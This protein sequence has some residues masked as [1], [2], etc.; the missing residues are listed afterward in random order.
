MKKQKYIHDGK[1]IWCGREEPAVTFE[2]KPHILP[3]ALGGDEICVD[4]CDECNHYFG[5]AEKYLPNIDLVVREILEA[6]RLFGTNYYENR[7]T[8]K[9]FTFFHYDLKSGKIKLKNTFRSG[10]ITFQFK[11]GLYELFLQKYHNVTH[12]GNDSC[13]DWVRQY[14]RYG[15]K[16]V[17]REPR[18][19]YA[20]NNI[21]FTP[22]EEDQNSV[23]MSDKLIDN[24]LKYGVFHMFLM[25]QNFFMEVLPSRFQ[26]YGEYYL[27][28]E[29]TKMLVNVKGDESV[30][31]LTNILDIDPFMIRYNS[32]NI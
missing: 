27:Q 5:T 23:L 8:P 15:S 19:Y 29:A 9:K 18:V 32:Q 6:Y 13:W 21:T 28:N 25:G 17:M 7:K 16:Y 2:S 1:C 12:N 14:A 30:Y 4:V 20:F 31:E 26:L 10:T 3:K 22:A 24:T 11:R